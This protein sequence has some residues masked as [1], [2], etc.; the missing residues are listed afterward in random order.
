MVDRRPATKF[1]MG[2]S[3]PDGT[4][5][6]VFYVTMHLSA[7][8][9]KER[10]SV[11][12]E[13]GTVNGTVEWVHHVTQFLVPAIKNGYKP[14]MRNKFGKFVTEWQVGVK[15]YPAQTGLV[16]AVREAAAENLQL[17]VTLPVVRFDEEEI[18]WPIE[19][20]LGCVLGWSTPGVEDR[21]EACGKDGKGAT[22]AFLVSG[23]A[24][25]GGKKK[26]VRH[27]R[28]IANFA[29]RALMGPVRYDAV[30]MGVVTDYSLSDMEY[31]CRVADVECWQKLDD[32]NVRMMEAVART[33]E[34]ELAML[35]VPSE[36]FSRVLLIP[37]CRLGSDA[38]RNEWRD[39]CKESKR[40]GQYFATFY[41]YT[42]LAPFFKVSHSS[43][44]QVRRL[45]IMWLFVPAAYVLPAR[46]S[47]S[48]PVTLLCR[49]L[50]LPRTQWGASYDM[51]EFLAPIPTMPKG[52]GPAQ[53][54]L[55]EADKSFGIARGDMVF[56]WLNFRVRSTEDSRALS[57]RLI[58]GFPTTLHNQENSSRPEQCYERTRDDTAK[59][60]VRCDVGLGFTIH[61]PVMAA[62]GKGMEMQQGNR[63]YRGLRTWHARLGQ[64]KW[65]HVADCDY[66]PSPVEG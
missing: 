38:D 51:D 14:G 12:L 24:L 48:L 41:S 26:D 25:Y 33:V 36:L 60:V 63:V 49:Y 37:S 21:V 23:S 61:H 59:S 39:P 6:L 32:W 27:F 20:G 13:T 65:A 56:Q 58:R 44:F 31:K 7:R 35:G 16:G 18:M 55:D 52:P 2:Q 11:L 57:V 17:N 15:L 10:A 22:G 64:L 47:N 46:V 53:P 45:A 66:S 62:T 5:R 34:E 19:M 43:S 29:A 28:E 1:A 9:T 3:D 30:A 40:Y 4:I 54:I 8:L 42:M 50:S